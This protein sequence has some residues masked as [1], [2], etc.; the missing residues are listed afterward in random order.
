M[1]KRFVHVTVPVCAAIIVAGAWLSRAGDL[2]PP[3][4]PIQPTNRVALNQQSITLPYTIVQSGSYVL[5]SNLTGAPGQ[6]G[7]VINADDVT[8]DLN[9]FSLFGASGTVHGIIAAAPGGRNISVVNGTVRGW[10]QRGVD[11]RNA[12]ASQVSRVRAVGNGTLGVAV[13]S[14]SAASEC[15]SDGNQTGFVSSGSAE[16]RD[17]SAASN[18]GD[19]FSVDDGS[20]V[21]DSRATG[22]GGRG[23]SANRSRVA[24][25][26]ARSNGGHGIEAAAGCV[27]EGSTAE[28]NGASS[29]GAGVRASGADN[30]IER[31][32][33]IDNDEGFQIA[34]T[35]NLVVKNSAKNS[36][37]DYSIAAGNAYGPIVAA[38]SGGNL[39]AL[40]DGTHPWANFG[41]SCV[42]Q[43]WCF[44]QDGDTFGNP[45]NTVNA[46]SPPPGYVA[47]CVDC[48]DND[49]FV[50][51]GASETCDGADNDCDGTSDEGNPGGGT[52]CATGN[53]GVCAVGTTNCV[54]GALQ[55]NQN[56]SPS[57]EICDGQ[58]NNCNCTVDEGNPGGGGA[59][60]TG[61]LGV[62]AAGT[63]NCISGSLSCTQNVSPSAEVC[64]GLDNNCN[65][66][67]DEGVC[68]ANGSVCSSASQ[69][70][71]GFCVDGRCCNSACTAT[72]FAC[73][74]AKTGAANGTCA[75]VIANTDPDNECTGA[76]NCNGAGACG[77]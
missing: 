16:F 10:G 44:D 52:P 62:C 43:T 15:N 77:S 14:S 67:V 21:I 72:C 35:R 76:A 73:S 4:G 57:V 36:G 54:G 25:C 41:L 46:C 27:I 2:N 37:A 48:N 29:V 71:S 55:C 28:S 34:G 42:A 5:T 51:P 32:H 66:S 24:D 22:N 65:G 26:V 45:S 64:D 39:A 63:L 1:K 11:L 30:R 3:A 18:I 7:I 17:C 40:T 50:N 47:N 33:A 9:G 12:T 56:V 75:P 74:A 60:N 31:N 61:L 69:C 70:V 58:D 20:L 53:C 8:L 68:L 6:S 59:C 19:G 49:A 23:I 38:G 13:G